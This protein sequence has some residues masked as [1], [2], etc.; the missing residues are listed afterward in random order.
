MFW[1]LGA[2]VAGGVLAA[3]QG[4]ANQQRALQQARRAQELAALGSPE[5]VY[6]AREPK[7]A[8]LVPRIIQGDCVIKAI[9][10]VPYEP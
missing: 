5:N 2:A 9:D 10:G 6:R 3:A 4:Q 1:A 8:P 7:H